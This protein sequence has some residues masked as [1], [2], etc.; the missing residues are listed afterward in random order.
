MAGIRDGSCLHASLAGL[1]RQQRCL[2]TRN[3]GVGQAAVMAGQH[4]DGRGQQGYGGIGGNDMARCRH[5]RAHPQ[6][7][8]KQG[9]GASDVQKYHDDT[10]KFF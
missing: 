1:E 6:D 8:S 10:S 2:Q 7:E 4:E 3:I 9:G 5:R